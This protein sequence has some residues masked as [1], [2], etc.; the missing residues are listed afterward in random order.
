MDYNN[1]N[2]D[3]PMSNN[4]G[5][6]N[7]MSNNPSNS[8]QDSTYQGGIYQDSAYPNASC[9]GSVYP[10]GTY[11]DSTYSN[12]AY[13]DSVYSNAT[14]QDSTYQGASYGAGNMPVIQPINKGMG[15]LGAALGAAIGGVAWCL[16]GMLGYVSAWL[17]V[18]IFFLAISLY[19][20]FSGTP[21]GEDAGVFGSSI[22]AVLGIL[23]ILPADYICYT[24]RVWRALNEGRHKFPFL[25][26]LGDMPLYM[27]RYDLWGGFFSDLVL[28]LFI[29]A[30]GAVFIICG[31]LK[32]RK[33]KNKI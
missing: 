27:E 11:Q 7:P 16:V 22:S 24:W 18:L 28:S 10:N 17:A 3:N 23:V 30:V 6:D 19:K 1:L 12:A 32:S 31:A 4:P 5:N 26:V 25:E 33:E 8:G 2:N 13:Q 21:N 14:Y 20:K 15:V 9:Q 29:M